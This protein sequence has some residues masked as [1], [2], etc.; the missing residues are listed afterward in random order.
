MLDWI[1]EHWDD[2][3]AIYGGLVAICTVI[4]KLTPNTKDDEI[5][6]KIILFLD[7]FSTAFRKADEEKL[8]K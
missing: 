2:V 5:L 1:I 8:K 7:T 3:L 6:G 4:V